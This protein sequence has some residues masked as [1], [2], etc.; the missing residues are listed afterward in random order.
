MSSDPSAFPQQPSALPQRFVKRLHS[1][2]P[3]DSID[4]VLS[5]Y[6]IPKPVHIRINTL[7][8]TDASVRDELC[9][10]GVTPEPISDMAGVFTVDAGA[11]YTLVRSPAFSEGRIYIQNLSSL[12]PVLALDV[13][14]G[15]RVLDLAAAPGG[16]TLHIADR[17]RNQ[18]TL[19]AVESSRPRYY[20]LCA[21]I[22]RYGA[23]CV[24]PVHADGRR[25]GGREPDTFDRVL[26]DAPCSGEALLG[27]IT[28][29]HDEERPNWSLAKIRRCAAKQLD[30]L[31]SAGD[32]CAPGGLLV[33]CTCTTA[34][35]ENEGV[36]ASF[37]ADY[38]H[39]FDIEPIVLPA[40]IDAAKMPGLSSWDGQDFPPALELCVRIV[41]SAVLSG[42]F[43]TRLRKRA[44]V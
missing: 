29:D 43:L 30:L 4:A 38:G 17:L 15:Q 21:Q 39:E 44:A 26:L 36:V 34:P 23:T 35:E 11:R 18:G 3:A 22:E 28:A 27:A 13:Q 8:A 9:R 42:F 19:M 12:L 25:I 10:L 40:S 41:P 5:S 20:K 16:K 37:L 6:S 7:R 33:Y 32:A 14:P 1:I 24:T 2:I 31:R